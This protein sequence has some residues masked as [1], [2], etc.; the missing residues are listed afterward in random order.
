MNPDDY[1]LNSDVTG[2]WFVFDH[3]KNNYMQHENINIK[4]I[5]AQGTWESNGC[6]FANTRDNYLL[7][8]DYFNL[9]GEFFVH[10]DIIG[11]LILA[12]SFGLFPSKDVDFD[13]DV[14]KGLRQRTEGNITYIQDIVQNR[15][16]LQKYF[17]VVFSNQSTPCPDCKGTGQYV[18]F[19]IIEP[20]RSCNG[21]KVE[22]ETIYVSP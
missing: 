5:L 15:Y 7:L 10:R 8:K 21:S 22:W 13:A 4:N 1:I 18:G 20:C 16:H 9:P 14:W 3:F 11:K 12:T 6:H 19:S 17:D 2:C